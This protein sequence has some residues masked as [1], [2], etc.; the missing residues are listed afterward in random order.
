[1]GVSSFKWKSIKDG[2]VTVY[3]EGENGRF[4]TGI[5][6]IGVDLHG[7]QMWSGTL[8]SKESG[9]L[10]TVNEFG[11]PFTSLESAKEAIVRAAK[12]WEDVQ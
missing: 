11:T 1:M 5:E 3:C 4:F 2:D 7:N 12:R 8:F 9:K 6:Y 10:I